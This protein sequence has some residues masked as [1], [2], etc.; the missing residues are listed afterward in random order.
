MNHGLLY[1]RLNMCS[2]RPVCHSY[3]STK[4]PSESTLLSNSDMGYR[5]R[6]FLRF[7]GL[8]LSGFALLFAVIGSGRQLGVNSGS[9]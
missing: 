5:L 9:K 4:Y 1:I 7:M 6:P 8:G 3:F 2:R